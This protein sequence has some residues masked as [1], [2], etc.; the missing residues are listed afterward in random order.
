MKLTREGTI[1]LDS[2]VILQPW[3]LEG[4]DWREYNLS[5][6]GLSESEITEAKSLMTDEAKATFIHFFSPDPR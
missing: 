4:A 5:E 2:D 1:Q 3:Y 6:L